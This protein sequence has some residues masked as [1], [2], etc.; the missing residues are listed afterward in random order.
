MNS[1][2]RTLCFKRGID[3]PQPWE[4]RISIPGGGIGASPEYVRDYLEAASK[5]IVAMMFDKGI[6]GPVIQ[7]QFKE[8]RR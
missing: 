5:V 6:S 8:D 3:D 1:N 4:L 7:G 2:R